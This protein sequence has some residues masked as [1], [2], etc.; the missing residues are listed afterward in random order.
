MSLR[1]IGKTAEDKPVVFTTWDDFFNPVLNH[2]TIPATTPRGKRYSLGELNRYFKQ[3]IPKATWDYFIENLR[4][5]RSDSSLWSRSLR[6]MID[7]GL[8]PDFTFIHVGC[9]RCTV[10]DG[11]LGE[12]ILAL[13]YPRV[14]SDGKAYIW[15]TFSVLAKRSETGKWDF[16]SEYKSYYETWLSSFKNEKVLEHGFSAHDLCCFGKEWDFLKYLTTFIAGEKTYFCS[17]REE[18]YTPEQVRQLIKKG[19]DCEIKF[20]EYGS[21]YGGGASLSLIFRIAWNGRKELY[22]LLS[23]NTKVTDLLKWPGE[24]TKQSKDKKISYN[25]KLPLYGVELEYST[26]YEVHNLIDAQTPE[27]FAICKSDGSTSGEKSYTGELVTIPAPLPYLKKRF[28]DWFSA[29]DRRL[30]D[31]SRNTNNGMHV[32]ISREAFSSPEHLNKFCWFVYNYHN[33]EFISQISERSGRSAFWPSYG[34]RTYTRMLT[35]DTSHKMSR[36][37]VKL[38][39]SDRDQHHLAVNLANSETVE[40]RIFKGIFSFATVLKNLEFTDALI[41]FTGRKGVSISQMTSINFVNWLYNE[42]QRSQYTALKDFVETYDRKRFKERLRIE[43]EMLRIAKQEMDPQEIIKIVREKGLKITDMHADAL[44]K[45]LG[46]DYFAIWDGKLNLAQ[47]QGARLAEKDDD[48]LKRYTNLKE[49]KIETEVKPKKKAKLS[50]GGL[51]D[52]MGR[53]VRLPATD[54][55]FSRPIDPQA[56]VYPAILTGNSET[57]QIIDDEEL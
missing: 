14:H 9:S 8:F 44:N 47:Y 31:I 18:S 11:G 50:L 39:S 37:I 25:P 1:L 24:I 5:Y 53:D 41:N 23:Y 7:Q 13:Y 15:D 4:V 28:A 45:H 33:L 6:E 21:R 32:H 46:G 12:A 29:L 19:S 54:I 16:V 52:S 34:S 20:T 22:R 57:C 35:K 38:I 49:K 55:R 56:L 26:D 40:L 2:Q 36:G 42:T 30:F 27:L 43:R 3:N 10:S 51:L 48:Y 17:N